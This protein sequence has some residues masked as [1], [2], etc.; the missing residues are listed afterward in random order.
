VRLGP[1]SLLIALAWVAAASSA[2]SASTTHASTARSK[3]EPTIRLK[4]IGTSYTQVYTDG[5]RWAVYEPT[6]GATRIIDT[7]KGASTTRPDPEGC[8]GGL[9]AVGGG[10]ILYACSDPECAEAADACVISPVHTVGEQPYK[11]PYELGRWVVEDAASGAEHQLNI[12]KGLPPYR[13]R[14]GDF[15]GRLEAIGSQW[16][17]SASR[18]YFVNWHTGQVVEEEEEPS[19][20]NR[21]YD[22]L[23]SEALFAPLCSP[24]E[25]SPYPAGVEYENAPRYDPFEYSPPF[26]IERRY[27]SSDFRF[28]PYLRR[29]GST[30]AKPLPEGADLG[31]GLLF[32]GGRDRVSRLN[33]RGP[34]WFGQSY[35]IVE[36]SKHRSIGSGT[37]STMAFEVV[38]TRATTSEPKT[39]REGAPGDRGP[40][41]YDVWVGRLPWARRS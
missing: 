8:A 3:N 37:T 31:D 36:P 39:F 26:M 41:L 14:Y 22:N 17:A 25:L 16:A 23:N 5:V 40:N 13:T 32:S 27:R 10:E 21:Y 6:E 7:I 1:I 20:A 18:S 29:C 11:S 35:R 38:A 2:A 12:G 33:P 24:L 28:H 9:I 34:S 4:P 15:T 30:R 19:S